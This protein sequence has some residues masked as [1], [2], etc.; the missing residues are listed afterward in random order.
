MLWDAVRSGVVQA[1]VLLAVCIAIEHVAPL[2]RFS[3]RQRIKGLLFVFVG[4]LPSLLLA[5]VLQRAWVSMGLG[6]SIVIPL[7]DCLGPWFYFPAMVVVSDFLIYW[8]HRV[9]HKWFWPIHA[10][11]HSP[12][13]LH[14]SNSWGHPLQVIPHFLFVAVP[15]SFIQM[16]G[17]SAP[18]AIGLI[19]SFIMLYE[20][21]PID[22]H[23]GALR[24]VFVDNRFHRIHHSIETEHREKNF[25]ICLSIWDAMFGTAY[26][27]KPKE[28][29]DVGI[30]EAPPGTVRDFLLYPYQL[31]IMRRRD[32]VP[33][34]ESRT[35]TSPP[36]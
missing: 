10:V 26:W 31:R 7:Y 5:W 36:L 13:E 33:A 20:H 2:E 1:F 21:S 4:L 17:P 11:H 35:V 15:L 12:R 28:W 34:A 14:A 3:V 9:E 23:F 8:R 22:F 6:G 29:P 27:P 32:D 30:D 18:L 24:R 19:I 16:P 25:G